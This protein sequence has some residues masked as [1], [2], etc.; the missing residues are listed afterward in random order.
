VSG[1]GSIPSIL[2]ASIPIALLTVG[3]P[4]GVAYLISNKRQNLRLYGWTYVTGVIVMTIAA[5][6]VVHKDW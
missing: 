4:Y 1:I 3:I 5:Y 6:V 2:G